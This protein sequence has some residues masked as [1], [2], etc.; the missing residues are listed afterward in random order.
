[1]PNRTEN[2]INALNEVQA[3]ARGEKTHGREYRIAP[4]EV[5]VQ[6]IRSRLDLSQKEFAERFGFPLGTLRNWEQGRRQPE[7]AARILLKI[8]DSEP[9][10][11]DKVLDGSDD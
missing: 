6:A 1:M 3:R 10:L 11:V 5:D 9:E 2:L 7:G 4:T 8:I